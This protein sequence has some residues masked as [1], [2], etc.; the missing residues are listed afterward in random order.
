MGA[1]ERRRRERTSGGGRGGGTTRTR[2]HGEIGGGSGAKS[3]LERRL[4]VRE[5][6]SDTGVG[7]QGRVVS[8]CV[9]RISAGRRRPRW[10][11]L[12]AGGGGGRR[13]RPGAEEENRVL[14]ARRQPCQPPLSLQQ[15]HLRFFLICILPFLSDL[16]L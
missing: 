13:L 10:S 15:V 3:S 6:G 4:H 2:R 9:V 14:G 5:G 16:S 11:A 1:H 8:I 7:G 12:A